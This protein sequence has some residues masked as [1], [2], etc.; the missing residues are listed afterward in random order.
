MIGAVFTWGKAS[1]KINIVNHADLIIYVSYLIIEMFIVYVTT[2]AELG[3]GVG[4]G[5]KPPLILR[6]GVTY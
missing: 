6:G 3:G 2:G 4:G 1:I 5:L